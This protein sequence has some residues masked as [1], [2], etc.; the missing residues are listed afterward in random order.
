MIILVDRLPLNSS[1]TDRKGS[2]V[3]SHV[4]R[5]KRTENGNENLGASHGLKIIRGGAAKERGN[6]EPA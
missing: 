3:P 4:K 6:E 1:H 5:D 2:S